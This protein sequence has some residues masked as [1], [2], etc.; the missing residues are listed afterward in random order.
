MGPELTV[1]ICTSKVQ[2]DEVCC[3]PVFQDGSIACEFHEYTVVAVMSHLGQDGA[4]H[5]R[6]ALRTRPQILRQTSPVQWLVTDDWRAP[7][8]T[9]M[10]KDW[11][12]ENITMA[13]LVR[14]DVLHLP[15][16]RAEPET[17]TTSTAE[18]MRL[19]NA[20]AT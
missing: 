11:M 12:Q 3:I 10:P 9:W 2:I 13:W 6:A 7:E 17:P 4:G 1:Y 14:T 8:P 20:A 18:L 5:Y 16:Y 15:Y 19:L